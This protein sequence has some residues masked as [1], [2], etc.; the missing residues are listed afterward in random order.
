[1][2]QPGTKKRILQVAARQFAEHGYNGTSLRKI[3][4]EADVNVAAAHYHFGSKAVLFRAVIDLFVR[5]IREERLALLEKCDDIPADSADLIERIF[6]ALLAP[7]I[8]L[9]RVQGGFDYVR[10]IARYASEPRDVILPLY[11]EVFAPLRL[12]F[13]QALGRAR[14]DLPADYLNRSY[15]FAIATMAASLVDPGYESLSGEPPAM[16]DLEQLIDMLVKFSAA[17]FRG[18]PNPAKDAIVA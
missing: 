1:M 17:G 8:H 5:H 7:H 15:G 16:D 12:R 3:M 6:H 2:S 14:P 13:I 4:R 9:L 18:L 11:K 10:I